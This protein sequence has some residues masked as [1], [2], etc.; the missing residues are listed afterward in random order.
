[1]RARSAGFPASWLRSFALTAVIGLGVIL[2]TV[3]AGVSSWSGHTFLGSWEERWIVLSLRLNICSFSLL[4]SAG[5]SKS[6]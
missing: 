3:L 5:G 4:W 6:V 2:P 1:M